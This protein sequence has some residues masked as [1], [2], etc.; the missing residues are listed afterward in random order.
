[1]SNQGEEKNVAKY[2]TCATYE[3]KIELHEKSGARVT[4]LQ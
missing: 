4:V 2:E 3:Q 1:M